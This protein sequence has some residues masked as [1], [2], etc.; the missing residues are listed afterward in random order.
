MNQEE[1]SMLTQSEAIAAAQAHMTA[2]GVEFGECVTVLE[3]ADGT[4]TLHFNRPITI[5]VPEGWIVTSSTRQIV[6]AVVNRHDGSV[7]LPWSL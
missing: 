2:N 4:V 1:L 6:I 3:F 7:Y 5:Q